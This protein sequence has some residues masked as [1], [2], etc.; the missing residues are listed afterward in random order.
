MD[1]KEFSKLREAY[2][3]N[4]LVP[5][6]G[7]GISFPFHLPGWGELIYKIGLNKHFLWIRWMR[8][9]AW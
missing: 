8:L 6:I 1:E 2:A 3:Y 5:V 7:S 4:Q 9:I